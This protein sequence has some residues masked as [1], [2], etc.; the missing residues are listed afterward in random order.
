MIH[1][2]CACS[3]HQAEAHDEDFRRGA[4]PRASRRQRH[5]PHQSRLISATESSGKKQSYALLDC[6][7]S[8]V[9]AERRCCLKKLVETPACTP[10]TH[11]RKTI[12]DGCH[13]LGKESGPGG[14]AP[15]VWEC[16]H[17]QCPRRKKKYSKLDGHDICSHIYLR[18][19][20]LRAHTLT[21]T[22]T[23]THTHIHT[24][25]HTHPHSHPHSHS[26]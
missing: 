14:K 25:T 24:H 19:R 8:T 22:L 21:H 23:L 20:T 17:T 9:C 12:V 5:C 15:R 18:A 4:D 16:N 1:S 13:P 6:I 26:H 3:R 10:G 11:R 2:H 7:T